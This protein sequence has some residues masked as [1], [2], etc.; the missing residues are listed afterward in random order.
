MN[1]EDQ[2]FICSRLN[3]AVRGATQ[4]VSV[5]Y[6]SRRSLGSEFRSHIDLSERKPLG[7]LY[8]FTTRIYTGPI[9]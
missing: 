7:L 2:V 1:I 6:D 9:L 5:Y 8:I 4:E 3:A